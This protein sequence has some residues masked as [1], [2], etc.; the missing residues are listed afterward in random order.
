MYTIEYTRVLVHSTCDAGT[1]DGT[2]DADGSELDPGL[3]YN[4]PEVTEEHLEGLMFGDY[5]SNDADMELNPYDEISSFEG[6][7][8]AIEQQLAEY[9]QLMNAKMNIVIFRFSKLC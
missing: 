1:Q 2:E 7:K 6:Y 5:L 4:W 9:N 8:G 3:K